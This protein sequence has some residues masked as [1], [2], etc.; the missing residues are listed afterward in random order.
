MVLYSRERDLFLSTLIQDTALSL[1]L[2]KR[3]KTTT[4]TINLVTVSKL[5]SVVSKFLAGCSS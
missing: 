1:I 3:M 5:T 2:S 4:P